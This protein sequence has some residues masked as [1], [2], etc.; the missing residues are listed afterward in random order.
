MRIRFNSI[1]I[2]DTLDRAAHPTERSHP[3]VGDEEALWRELSSHEAKML[4][5]PTDPHIAEYLYTVKRLLD[6][7]LQHHKAKLTPYWS[8]KGRFRQMVYIETI[9]QALGDLVG[10]I[11]SGHPA[12][13]LARRLDA[14][15]GL[16]LDLWI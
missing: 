11:R 3:L 16:M 9:N 13:Q 7:A 14:I 6:R 4:E 8:P 5:N 10:A 15:R 12:T 1:P 2:E